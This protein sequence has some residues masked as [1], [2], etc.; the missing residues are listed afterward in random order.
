MSNILIY[1]Y[2]ATELDKRNIAL[3]ILEIYNI[4]ISLQVINEFIWMNRK[5]N[6]NYDKLEIKECQILYT[7][8]MQDGQIIEGRLKIENPY[9]F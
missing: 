2:S 1:A 6:I 5:F 8:D 7:E 9:K 4:V 3:A